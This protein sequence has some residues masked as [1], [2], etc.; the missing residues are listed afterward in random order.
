MNY[1]YPD[2]LSLG[3]ALKG[4]EEKVEDVRVGLLGFQKDVWTIREKVAGREEEVNALL[5][6]KKNLVDQEEKGRTLLEISERL[7]ELESSLM[8][9]G[10]NGSEDGLDEDEDE[11]DSDSE[12]KDR[13]DRMSA[14]NDAKGSAS[15]SFGM[16]RRHIQQYMLLKSL[17]NHVGSHHPFLGQQ[18]QRMLRIRTTLLLDLGTAV[19]EAKAPPKPDHE[20]L[21]RLL[22]L[23][24]KMSEGADALA[25]LRE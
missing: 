18:E 24:D 1:N 4:G 15:L 9:D 17:A 12:V 21:L 14:N 2:F 16:V 3:A 25:V 23:Y 6:T 20:K 11:D 8:L 19:K 10:K 7:D 22:R 13:D 5:I